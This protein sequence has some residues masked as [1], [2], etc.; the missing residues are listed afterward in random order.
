MD[1]LKP[2]RLKHGDTIGVVSPASPIADPSKIE[3]GV[4]YLEKNGYR[5]IV[6][7]HAGKVNG[8]LA[9]TDEERVSDLHAMFTD[10]RVKAII[11]V[12]GGYG[13]PR[14][15]SLINYA[16]IRRNPKIVVGFSDIT[17]LQIALWKRC[18][19][20][21]FHGPMLGVDM[22]GAN[23]L[24]ASLIDPFTEQFFWEIVTSG[25][26][27]G[28]LRLPADSG[29]SSLRGGTA[30]GRLLGGNLSLI[31]TLM[32]TPYQMDFTGSVFFTEEVGEEPYRIDR[33]LMQLHMSSTF[34]RMKAMLAGQFTDCVPKDSSQPSLT[35]SELLA[36]TAAR[37]KK[38]FLANLPFGH[39]ARKI[40]LPVGLRVAI[41]ADAGEITFLEPAVS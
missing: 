3:H 28:K 22:A 10:K 20:I 40:T 41:N 27:M 5:V 26:K 19:L 32:G 15:L 14:L 6:G 35:V 2:E 33:M 25:T 21:T 34:R 24:G 30:R 38:P 36:E 13:T 29:I 9:G 31:T 16:L 37:L 23:K 7:K 1:P 4:R 12:R 8:Y 17:A 18:R 11:S 39:A